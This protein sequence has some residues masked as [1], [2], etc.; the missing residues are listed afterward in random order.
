MT[1]KIHGG[2][3]SYTLLSHVCIL[4]HDP[5]VCKHFLSSNTFKDIG[6]IHTGTETRF[7]GS[8][9]PIR[10]QCSLACAPHG[11]QTTHISLLVLISRS[12]TQHCRTQLEYG[13]KP[14]GGKVVGDPDLRSCVE[15]YID[16]ISLH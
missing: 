12:A 4:C 2:F 14:C 9:F 11:T 13:S 1:Q 3:K 7:T 10:I 6:V 5:C 16:Y 15:S 8:G